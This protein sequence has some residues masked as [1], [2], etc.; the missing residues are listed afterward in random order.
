MQ[1]WHGAGI[2]PKYLEQKYYDF[3]VESEPNNSH[4]LFDIIDQIRKGAQNAL[5]ADFDGVEINAAFGHIFDRYLPPRHNQYSLQAQEDRDRRME[6]LLNLADIIGHV[7][8]FERVGVRICPTNIYSGNHCFDPDLEFYS[9]VESLNSYPLAYVHVLEPPQGKSV[10]AVQH[11]RLSKLI[12]PIYYG[13]LMIEGDNNPER[14]FST[15]ANNQADLVSFETATIANPD[16]PQRL[17][18]NAPLNTLDRKTIHGSDK[19]GYIDYP[20][21]TD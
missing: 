3:E 5:A 21:L 16:L 13:N 18:Q 14:A 6:M 19:K 4:K 17:Q 1:L 20:F 2:S 11:E 7:W 8:D 10:L 12:R 15:I 9:G